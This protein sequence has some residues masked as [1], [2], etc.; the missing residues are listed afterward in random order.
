MA[1]AARGLTPAAA[2]ERVRI[3]AE[4]QVVAAAILKA[5]GLPKTESVALLGHMWTVYSVDAFKKAMAAPCWVVSEGASLVSE[6]VSPAEAACMLRDAGWAKRL[7][8]MAPAKAWQARSQCMHAWEWTSSSKLHKAAGVRVESVG[9]LMRLC[10]NDGM[11]WD[12][13]F[14]GLSGMMP[15]PSKPE[16][17]AC[18]YLLREES[19][20]QGRAARFSRWLEERDLHEAVGVA[21]PAPLSAKRRL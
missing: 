7:A 13:M 16:R 10:A 20:L 5:V 8:Q 12:A 3:D 1:R 17:L 15:T 6:L 18:L 4:A 2:R 11:E 19:L 14:E 21:K 9:P